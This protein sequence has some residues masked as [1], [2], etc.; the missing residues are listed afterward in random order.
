M[1]E[2][3]GEGEGKEGERG[4]YDG[5]TLNQGVGLQGRGKRRYIRSV[6]EVKRLRGIRRWRG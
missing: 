2:K 1:R 6:T 5:T 4:G 3:S